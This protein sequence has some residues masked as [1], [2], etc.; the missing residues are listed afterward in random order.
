MPKKNGKVYRYRKR[1]FNITAVSD[2]I[3]AETELIIN[4]GTFDIKTGN[5]SGDTNAASFDQIGG[6]FG[7]ASEEIPIKPRTVKRVLKQ[8]ISLL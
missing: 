3:Q 8:E 7:R 6:G 5:G 1:E 2:A 4:G